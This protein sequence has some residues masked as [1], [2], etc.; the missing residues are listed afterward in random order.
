MSSE[1]LALSR[2]SHQ[3]VLKV[4]DNDIENGW[5]VGEYHSEG[6]LRNIQPCLRAICYLLLLRFGQ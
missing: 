2:I 5:F 3:N 4:L 1:V 6:P